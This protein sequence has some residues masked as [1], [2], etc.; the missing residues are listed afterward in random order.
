VRIQVKK[1][2][3]GDITSCILQL[4]LSKYEKIFWTNTSWQR[5]P[6]YIS[7][8]RQG[9]K[10]YLDDCLHL[11]LKGV[12]KSVDSKKKVVTFPFAP[13]TVSS[14]ISCPDGI[15]H[16]DSLGFLQILGNCWV[17]VTFITLSLHTKITFQGHFSLRKLLTPSITNRI[18]SKN[19]ETVM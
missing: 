18:S 9:F 6:C 8:N 13:T 2:S 1:S 15:D 14:D 16:V 17:L 4:Y 12:S 5:N 10:L 7:Y 19:E 3:G 11:F